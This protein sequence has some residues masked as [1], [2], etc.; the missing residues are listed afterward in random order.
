MLDAR[1]LVISSLAFYPNN[2]DPDAGARA[3]ANEH[4]R[5]VIVGA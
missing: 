1:G 2:L 3:S 5:K 4:L